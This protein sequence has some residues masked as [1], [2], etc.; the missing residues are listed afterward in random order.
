MKHETTGAW[1]ALNN[2]RLK[3]YQDQQVYL[4]NDDQFEIELFNGETTE[5]LAQIWLNDELISNSGLV[6]KPGQRF[7]LDRHIDSDRKL[8]FSTY[9]VEDSVGSRQAI[10]NNGKLKVQF[11]RKQ[12]LT[13]P[14]WKSDWA[15]MNPINEPYIP[16]WPTTIP[17][18]EP[19]MPNWQQPY[20]TDNTGDIQFNTLNTTTDQN[21]SI[22]ASYYSSS[23]ETGRIEEGDTSEQHFE[24]TDTIFNQLPFKTS[25][26]TILPK[27]RK[28]VETK[29]IRNY[30]SECGTRIRKK[31]WKYCPNCGEKLD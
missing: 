14:L 4:A 7:Y 25:S 8:K 12:E 19:N 28:P 22:N 21:T 27:S 10:K 6:L 1:I 9:R 15:Q 5:V 16:S 23:L 24:F 20:C 11:F 29:N 18:N 13:T 2:N 17:I 26:Y 31:G 3:I 30:C